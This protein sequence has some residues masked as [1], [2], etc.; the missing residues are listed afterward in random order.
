[1][2]PW[3]DLRESA[4]AVVYGRSSRYGAYAVAAAVE[5]R[6]PG[7]DVY[8]VNW[9]RGEP[10]ELVRE[11][12][13]RYRRVVVGV[14]FNSLQVP[15]VARLVAELR[16]FGVLLVAGGPHATGDPAGTLLRL[17]FDVAVYGEG[18]DTVVELLR[19]YVE[20][21]EY[22]VCGTAYT[23][24]GRVVVRVRSRRVDL[25]SYPPY[26]YWRGLYCPVEV[27]RGCSGGCRFCQV[28]YAFGPP[29]YRSVES[30]VRY[31]EEA[32]RRGIRDLRFVA[33]NSLGYGS[34]DGIRP[35]PAKLE[36][37]LSSLRGVA[38]RYGGRVFYG[39]FPTE[40][41]PDSV[42]EETASVLRR[43]VDNRRVV[44][45]AQSGSERV[46]RAVHRTHGVEDVVNAVS[47]LTAKGF[48]V[49]VDLI[50][51]LPGE[52]AE[53]LE[54]TIRLAERLVAMGA[55]LHLHTFMPLPGTPLEDSE[56]PRLSPEVRRRLAKLVGLGR[57]YGEWLEQEEAA[58]TLYELKTAGLVYRRSERFKLLRLCGC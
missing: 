45:G 49:D 25:D 10:L 43:Y 41:R 52:G 54:D 28:T 9:D 27:M 18:E 50:V 17:G 3:V 55:R 57:A 22:R 2:Y 29:R 39:S 51:G 32:L 34:P 15:Y 1:M 47:I 26:P 30:V 11:L 58:R 7:L 48:S 53:D 16:R 36:E 40:V 5:S 33:P 23:E 21:G 44:V 37:L 12:T 24:G 6:L 14:S 42:T 35:D 31:S 38:D 46:L 19:E 13:E 8:L 56:P 20:S 4:F